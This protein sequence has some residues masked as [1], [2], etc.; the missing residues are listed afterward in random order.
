MFDLYVCVLYNTMYYI[1][2]ISCLCVCKHID[3]I[4]NFMTV[5]SMITDNLIIDGKSTLCCHP[6]L[7]SLSLLR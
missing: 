5:Y 4:H 3:Y 2:T 6:S 7:L 1:E